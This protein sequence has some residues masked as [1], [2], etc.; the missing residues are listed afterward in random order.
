MNDRRR[1]LALLASAL[2]APQRT[3]AQTPARRLGVISLVDNRK[4][5][6]M[7]A[8]VA[9]LHELGLADGKNFT[10]DYRQ[11]D[12]KIERLPVLAA[13]LVR[14]NCDVLFGA[15]NEANLVALRQ[16]TRDTPIVFVSLDFDLVAG[17]HVDSLARPGGRVTGVTAIESALPAKRLELLKDM[18]PGARKIAVLANEQ[19]QKTLAVAQKAASRLGLSL[20]VLDL[21]HPPFDFEGAYANAVQAKS[22]AL[23]VLASAYWVPDRL[24]LTALAIKAKL[25]AMFPHSQWAAEGGLVSYGY[26]FPSLFR[27]GADMVAKILKGAK[28]AEMPIEQP[29]VYQLTVN[30]KTASAIGLKISRD[31]LQRADL[32]IE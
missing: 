23:L 19:T 24:K 18:I 27:T 22:D 11:A 26:D 29:A 16:A 25:P 2:A 17:G 3:L 9:R 20:H 1:M 32:L 28:P 5:P 31:F 8:F 7:R 14:A 12:S 21:T 15:G 4:D 30:R 13:E 10:I 6:Y